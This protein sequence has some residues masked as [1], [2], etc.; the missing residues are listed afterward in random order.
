MDRRAFS[1]KG[2]Y[3]AP[4]GVFPDLPGRDEEMEVE[5]LGASPVTSQDEEVAWRLYLELDTRDLRLPA[6]VDIIVVLDSDEG[7]ESEVTPSQPLSGSLGPA[8]DGGLS[9]STSSPGWDDSA[10]PRAEAVG[11]APRPGGHA[12]NHGQ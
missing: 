2:I 11:A 5:D 8:V 10:S 6:E 4:P 9:T 1:V 12:R 7:D 3:G